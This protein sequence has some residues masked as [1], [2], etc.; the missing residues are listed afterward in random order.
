M[1]EKGVKPDY[2]NVEARRSK[3]S[4][5]RMS[6]GRRTTY[7]IGKPLL[8][9]ILFVLTATYRFEKVIGKDIAVASKEILVMAGE[10]VMS[11]ARRHGVN[12]TL[13]DPPT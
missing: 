10:I 4:G 8:R 3:R 12:V 6:F 11:E 2:S 5:R 9:F 1:N 13:R 7:A